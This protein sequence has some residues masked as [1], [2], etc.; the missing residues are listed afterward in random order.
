V[1]AVWAWLSRKDTF[2]RGQI[3]P[4]RVEFMG[5]EEDV[6]FGQGNYNN[7]HGPF[8]HLPAYVTIMNAPTFREMQYLYGSYVLS[9]R[10]IR[11]ISLTMSVEA[12]GDSTK[13]IVELRAYT[14]PLVQSIWE[15]L[16]R[17]FWKRGF[18]PSLE[19]I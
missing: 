14:R 13:V 3:P 7:H 11:P 18:F 10:L 9:Y 6:S 5:D 1:E 4:Y 16:N 17:V 19:R 15:S 2:T 12:D 8:L